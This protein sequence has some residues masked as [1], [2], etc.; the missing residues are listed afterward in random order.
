ML[1]NAI[2]RKV[3]D[4]VAPNY[5]DPT[6][7]QFGGKV[8]VLMEGATAAA[9]NGLVPGVVI[10][11][12]NSYS[13]ANMQYTADVAIPRAIGYSAGLIDFFFRGKLEIEPITQR[14]FGVLNQ[15][16]PHTVN[17]DGYPTRTSN[18][19]I[20]GFEKIRLKIR[21]STDVITESGTNQT[22]PQVVGMGKLVAVARYHRNPC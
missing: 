17:A 16:E 12:F 1:Y 5:V 4:S 18:G 21:N 15:G 14:V 9:A 2:V 3:I 11:K 19:K 10:G 8:P 22:V 13:Y 20:F 6:L 7:A